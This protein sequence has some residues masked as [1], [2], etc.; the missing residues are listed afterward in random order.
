MVVDW[1][2]EGVVARVNIIIFISRSM[3]SI[4]EILLERVILGSKSLLLIVEI[5]G[6]VMLLI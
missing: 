6:I 4:S 1:Q 3:Q 2:T 5:D